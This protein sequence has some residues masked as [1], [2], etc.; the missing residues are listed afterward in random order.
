MDQ[1]SGEP[2]AYWRASTTLAPYVT[3]YHRFDA[4]LPPDM[5]LRDV[6][7]PSWATIRV[8]LPDSRGW[9][10]R[11]GSR[12]F[13]SVPEAVLIGATSYA[14][15]VETKGGALCGVGILPTGWA[16]LFGGDASR[17]ANRALPLASVAPDAAALV[18]AIHDGEAPD[19]AFERWLAPRIGRHKPDPRIARLLAIMDDPAD[20]RIERLTEELDM[21]QRALADFARMHFGFTPKLLL[22]RSRFLHA[23]SAVLSHPEDGA[24]VLEKA[25]YWDRSP[26]CATA[27]SSS[28]ARCASS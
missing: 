6:L 21:P 20:V 23:L 10:L 25:G 14:G 17:L 13:N 7:F 27:T 19:T 28:A 8:T 4:P 18:A 22:R 2:I 1:G 26:A 5:V 24:A 9:S 3:G 11:L 16:A 15:Y 12:R